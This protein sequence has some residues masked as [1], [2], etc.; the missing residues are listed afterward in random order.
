MLI[1][2]AVTLAASALVVAVAAWLLATGPRAPEYAAEPEAPA[3]A[4]PSAALEERRR[5]EETLGRWAWVDRER[6]VVA[7]PIDE[8]MAIVA[9]RPDAAGR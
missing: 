5:A 3:L 9:A 2:L 1:A 8:A 6:G 4:G 7:M